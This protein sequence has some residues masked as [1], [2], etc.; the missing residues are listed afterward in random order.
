MWVLGHLT[1]QTEAIQ[2]APIGASVQA[3]V[4]DGASDN[5]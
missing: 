4:T 1:Q 3:L 5:P 2:A